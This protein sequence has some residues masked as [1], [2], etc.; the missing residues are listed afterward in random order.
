MQNPIPSI[1]MKV[2]IP[3]GVVDG[4][5]IR[6]PTSPTELFV[7]FQVPESKVL[8]RKGV[9]VYS[10]VGVSFTHM[11]LGGTIEIP[12][13]EGAVKLVVSPG[14]EHGEMLHMLGK[15]IPRRKRTGRG[16]HYVYVKVK[17]PTQLST[18]QK[19]LLEKV[20]ALDKNISGT[21]DGVVRRQ[22][23]HKRK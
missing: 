18:R 6:V 23:K 14:T 20:A 16:H 12:G 13:L 15:G 5:T 17:L 1:T 9:D 11:L 21:V 22:S 10:D 19:L 4:E 8:R 2:N 7:T 3:A